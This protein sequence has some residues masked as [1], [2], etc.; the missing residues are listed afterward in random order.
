MANTNETI[1]Q[2]EN[3][4]SAANLAF[5]D[6]LPGVDISA[7]ETVKIKAM[8][9]ALGLTKLLFHTDTGG[10]D[11]YVISTGLSLASLTAGFAFALKTTT[12]NTGACTLAVDSVAAVAIKVVDASGVRDPY[13]GEIAAGMTALL[14]YNGTN[15]I[16]LNPSVRIKKY[17]AI[18][19]QTETSAP[20]A[21]ILENSL[22]GTPVWTRESLG[23]Y[24]ATLTNKFPVGY[25]IVMPAN[26]HD[27]IDDKPYL[28]TWNKSLSDANSI[29]IQNYVSSTRALSDM[30]EA[31][32]TGECVVEIIVFS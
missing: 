16:L 5:D 32:D 19:S 24:K 21:S 14:S 7:E 9:A 23:V 11:A 4:L 13:N 29:T 2:L 15:F 26:A 8:S 28:T 18:L 31:G 6:L 22:G 30:N 25:T 27:G 12:G 20:I 17:V 1:S 10:D 3:E